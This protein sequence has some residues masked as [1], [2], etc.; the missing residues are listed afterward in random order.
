METIYIGGGT[1]TALQI[2]ELK[3]LFEIL[4]PYVR[5]TTEYTIEANPENV[6]EDTINLF[7]NY[8]I[9]RVSLG[10]QCLDDTILK[11]LNRKHTSQEALA[12]IDSLYAAGIHNI[13]ADM[14]YGLPTQSTGRFVSDLKRLGNTAMFYDQ[15]H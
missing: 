9:N 2:S 14:I 5:E 1:P 7:V 13:S 10:V 6:K 11:L 4:K 8:G 3:C 12:V 15:F